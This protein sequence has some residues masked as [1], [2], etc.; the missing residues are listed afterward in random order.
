F[1]VF[2]NPTTQNLINV[3]S[4]NI[5][6]NKVIRVVNAEGKNVLE[7]TSNESLTELDLNGLS[8]GL[9]LLSITSEDG[10]VVFSKFIKQ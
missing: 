1:S 6:G 3:E 8:Y 7:K 9:Y 2:P 10:N 4:G 5:K